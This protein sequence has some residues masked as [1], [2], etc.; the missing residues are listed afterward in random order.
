M[1]VF[2]H[3][4]EEVR[5]PEFEDMEFGI[6]RWVPLSNKEFVVVCRLSLDNGS[7]VIGRA[8][9]NLAGPIHHDFSL[10]G[11]MRTAYDNLLEELNKTFT[12]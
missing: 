3:N 7:D 10:A 11:P 6:L 2:H 4:G 8:H 9:I 5:V 1:K 12:S